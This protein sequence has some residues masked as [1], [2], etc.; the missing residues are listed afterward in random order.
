MVLFSVLAPPGSCNDGDIRL[1]G[2]TSD[3]FQVCYTD[4]WGTVC[5]TDEDWDEADATVACRQL[6]YAGLG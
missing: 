3:N 2:G 5:G 6:E 4:L 1:E